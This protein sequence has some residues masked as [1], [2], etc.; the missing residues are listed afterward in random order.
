MAKPR[1]RRAGRKRKV[2]LIREPGGRI[3]RAAYR[4]PIIPEAVLE[5]RKRMA[6]RA[7]KD[8]LRT[9]GTPLA[10]LRA[11]GDITTMQFDAGEKLGSLRSEERRVGKEWRYG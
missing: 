3:S 2:D 1:R 10:L 8:A 5:Q 9:E 4:E 11:N 7:D 6:P